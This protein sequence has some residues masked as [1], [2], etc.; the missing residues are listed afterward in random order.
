M[1]ESLLKQILGHIVFQLFCVV[2]MKPW[3]DPI[4]NAFSLKQ[5]KQKAEL[6]VKEY[7]IQ[8]FQAA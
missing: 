8:R 3:T 1:L 5:M 4:T 6:E 2:S 7:W